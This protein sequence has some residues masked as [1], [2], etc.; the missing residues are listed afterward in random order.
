MT[1]K[2]T[3]EQ[4]VRDLYYSLDDLN[5]FGRLLKQ[6]MFVGSDHKSI[7]K[8]DEF[9]RKTYKETLS[10]IEC[11]CWYKSEKQAMEKISIE[12]IMS[13]SEGEYD[14]KYKVTMHDVF[15]KVVK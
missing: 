14:P 10:K 1:E 13:D 8:C 5:E 3:E 6:G 2:Q 11:N 7:V 4:Q 15:R 9:F 12:S